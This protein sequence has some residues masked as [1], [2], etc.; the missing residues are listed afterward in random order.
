MACLSFRRWILT[1]DYI[2]STWS[3]MSASLGLEQQFTAAL[4]GL[5]PSSRSIPLVISVT[6]LVVAF[7]FYSNFIPGVND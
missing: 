3:N 1:N 4:H 5:A 7:R 2:W 6:E